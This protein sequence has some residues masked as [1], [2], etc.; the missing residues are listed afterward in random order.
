MSSYTWVGINNVGLVRLGAARITALTDTS[1]AATACNA[2]YELSRDSVLMEYEW[3]DAKKRATLAADT[4]APN[5]GYDYRYALPNDCLR[6]LEVDNEVEHVVE[7]GYI[8]TDEPDGLD[9]LYIKQIVNPAEF[10][11]PHL[12]Q[13]V[14][15]KIAANICYHIVQSK[16]LKEE[17]EREYIDVLAKAKMKDALMDTVDDEDEDA[18]EGSWATGGR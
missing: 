17:I 4:T 3:R 5:H 6:L 18:R 16:T 8:L 14:A 1:K 10:R 9:I 2:Q 12:V 11:N 13:A 15:L 7:G